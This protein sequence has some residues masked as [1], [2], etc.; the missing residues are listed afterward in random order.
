M[1]NLNLRVRIRSSL[2]DNDWNWA[3]AGGLGGV[4]V[5][6]GVCNASSV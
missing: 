4:C 6:D 2:F 5:T 1:G 3:I